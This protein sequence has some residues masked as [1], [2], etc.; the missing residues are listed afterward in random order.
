MSDTRR[1]LSRHERATLRA[2]VEAYERLTQDAR[3]LTAGQAQRRDELLRTM[4]RITGYTGR[5][6]GIKLARQMIN[7]IDSSRNRSRSARYTAAPGGRRGRGSNWDFDATHV[8]AI[9]SAAIESSRR[10]H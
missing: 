2:V 4:Q 5:K 1:S 3:A 6:S 10:R 9:V 8:E 7:G